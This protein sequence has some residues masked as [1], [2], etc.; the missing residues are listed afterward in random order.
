MTAKRN[1]DINVNVN[2]NIN[3]NICLT[4]YKCDIRTYMKHHG[5]TQYAPLLPWGGRGI[6][7]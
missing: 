6:T 4:G 2:L 7:I 3:I 1:M 5:E